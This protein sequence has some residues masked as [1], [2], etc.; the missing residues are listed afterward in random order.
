MLTAMTIIHIL[1][2]L[3]LIFLVLLQ[4]SKGGMGALSGGGS[5]SVLG[6]TGAESLM[7][8][9]TRWVAVFFAISCITL[10]VYTSVKPGSVV[11]GFVAPPAATS[12]E[13]ALPAATPIPTPT[14]T[15]ATPAES[16]DK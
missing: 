11:D 8:K 5:N 1:I 10:T 2:C 13:S 4:D 3:V 6:A 15:E 12:P 16:V 14:P 7:S 9:L